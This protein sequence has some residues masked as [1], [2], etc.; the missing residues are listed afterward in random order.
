MSCVFSILPVRGYLLYKYH[1]LVND[2]SPISWW[3][4]S[5]TFQMMTRC[6]SNHSVEKLI[7]TCLASKYKYHTRV[8]EQ[9]ASHASGIIVQSINKPPTAF[10]NFNY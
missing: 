4:G 9:L 3:F 8:L 10:D 7:S 5:Q 2:H 1:V 6:T